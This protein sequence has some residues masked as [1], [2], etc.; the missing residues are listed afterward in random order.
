LIVYDY[1]TRRAY[2]LPDRRAAARYVTQMRRSFS[3][4]R[5]RSFA[6]GFDPWRRLSLL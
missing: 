4:A 1:A 6:W 2:R 3:C 5:Q